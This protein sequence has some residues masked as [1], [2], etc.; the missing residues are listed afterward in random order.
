MLAAPTITSWGEVFGTLPYLSPEYVTYLL[1][2]RREHYIANPAEDVHALGVILYWLLTGRRPFLQRP[3]MSVLELLDQIR[4]VAPPH[5][6][7]GEEGE[8][9]PQLLGDLVMR[10]LDK[11]PR[12]RPQDGKA[13]VQALAHVVAKVGKHLEGVPVPERVEDD[14]GESPLTADAVPLSSAPAEPPPIQPDVLR[15]IYHLK[16]VAGLCVTLLLL[17]LSVVVLSLWRRLPPSE[18]DHVLATRRE[19]SRTPEQELVLEQAETPP[20]PEATDGGTA[21]KEPVKP[22]KPLPSH[23]LPGQKEAPCRGNDEYERNQGCWY[24]IDAS[25]PC[26]GYYVDGKD[27]FTPVPASA[28]PKRPVSK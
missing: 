26:P 3:G 7:Q 15:Q 20:T 12:K 8:K 6:C 19:P 24:R 1:G 16:V 10:M 25:P 21:P 11:D 23:P 17:I 18:S 4:H 5:P 28:K 13:V 9:V 22:G 27:C 2:P 14:E